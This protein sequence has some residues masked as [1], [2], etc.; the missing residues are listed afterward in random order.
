M[1]Q[2]AIN[3]KVFKERRR[4]LR[5]TQT[6]A[7]EKLW[8]ILRAKKLGGFKFYRQ[9]SFG[10]FILDFYCP[11]KKLAIE[12]DGSQHIDN[13]YDNE[14]TRYLAQYEIQVLRFWNNDIL[15]NIEG[16]CQ[17]IISATAPPHL[18]SLR[19]GLVSAPLLR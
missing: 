13:E 2:T 4:N 16:V 5:Q 7:E 14:R 18:P 17:E 9:Y 1:T 19:E 11:S 10:N 6:D 12:A 15:N 3:I 8:K